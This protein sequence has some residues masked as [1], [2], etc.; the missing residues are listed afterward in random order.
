MFA[1]NSP[2]GSSRR[3]AESRMRHRADASERKRARAGWSSKLEREGGIRTLDGLS[4]IHTFQ[5]CS[6]G[7]SDTSPKVGGDP[8]A[9]PRR[10]SPLLP[11]LPSGPD[12]VHNL[13]SRGDRWGHHRAPGGPRNPSRPGVAGGSRSVLRGIGLPSPAERASSAPQRCAVPERRPCSHDCPSTCALALERL[14]AETIGRVRSARD[15]SY[16]AGVICSKVA[17]YAERIHHPDRLTTPLRRVGERGREG[18]LSEV[19]E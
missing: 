3:R 13:S 1:H 8:P 15:N 5:A 6:F 4:P 2:V 17:R 11:L 9:T 7:R 18:S 16:A 19:T 14:D 10:P 12:G